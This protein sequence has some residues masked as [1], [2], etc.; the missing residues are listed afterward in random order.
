MVI[1]RY[2]LERA[3]TTAQAWLGLTMGCAVC[4]DHK[5]DPITTRDFYSFYAFFHSNADPALDGNVLLTAPV[6]KVHVA[7]TGS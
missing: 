4:H 5:Y 7:L 6:V 3:S 2:A 1:F